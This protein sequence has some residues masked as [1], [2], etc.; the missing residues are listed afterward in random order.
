M[1]VIKHINPRG[2]WIIGQHFYYL[3]T[4]NWKYDKSYFT[5]TKDSI[6]IMICLFPGL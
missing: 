1:I 3:N 2:Y 4:K 6:S 5:S